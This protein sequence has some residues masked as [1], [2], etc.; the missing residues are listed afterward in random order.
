MF[1]VTSCRPS[2]GLYAKGTMIAHTR[3][4]LRWGGV[5]STNCASCRAYVNAMGG[6]TSSKR[7]KKERKVLK[8]SCGQRCKTGCDQRLHSRGVRSIASRC[9]YPFNASAVESEPTTSRRRRKTHDVNNKA[10]I[11]VSFILLH[12][13]F[14]K[15]TR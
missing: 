1:L 8:M 12:N 10:G 13:N 6:A 3:F 7:R 11:R 14:Q 9:S 15:E 2:R 4:K 5:P